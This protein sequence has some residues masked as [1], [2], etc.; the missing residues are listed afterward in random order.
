MIVS[1]VFLL[2]IFSNKTVELDFLNTSIIP[3]ISTGNYQKITYM[4]GKKIICS[5]IAR[6]QNLRHNHRLCLRILPFNFSDIGGN[7][8]LKHT[9]WKTE[10]NWA[11]RVIS[12]HLLLIFWTLV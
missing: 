4:Y 10:K 2:A 11:W 7:F 8:S 1:H 5:L 6:D 3:S 12:C 9:K